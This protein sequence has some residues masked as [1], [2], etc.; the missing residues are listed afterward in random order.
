MRRAVAVAAAALLLALPAAAAAQ[1]AQGE[2]V[3]GGGSFANAPLL[4]PGS[5]RDTILPG[6][7]LYYA[8]RLQAGQQLRV[9]ARLDVE[10]GAIDPEIADG[11]SIGMQTP[12][13]EV[14]TDTD[15]DRT[16]NST[17]GDVEDR[18]DVVY[19]KVLAPS[20]TSDGIGAYM[21]PGV[22]YPS[23]YLIADERKPAKVELPV[24][25]ELQVVGDPQPD[26]SPEPTPAKATPTA[27]P[28]GE[29]QDGGTSAAAVAGIGLLGLLV[30]LLGGGLA[31]RRPG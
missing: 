7:R 3:V 24:E 25:F 21:A 16:G 9:R 17:V 11:F 18:F 27:T 15:E 29:D 22:W 23:L 8:V 19:P 12:L 2:A 14:I 10:P 30:G 31:A 13:R 1:T 5:Y 6:E 20:A 26:A 28:E 4:E